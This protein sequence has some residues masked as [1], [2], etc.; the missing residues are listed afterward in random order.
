MALLAGNNEKSRR[1]EWELTGNFRRWLDVRLRYVDI[2][3][4]GDARSPVGFALL[5]GLQVGQNWLWTVN[6]TRQLGQYLQLTLSYEGRQTGMAP[7]V[8]VGRAQVTAI[9]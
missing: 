5:N 4:E 9:F 3:L 6:T 2:A 1:T 8:H 7:T